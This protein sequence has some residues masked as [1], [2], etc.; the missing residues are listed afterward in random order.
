[1]RE[2]GDEAEPAQQLATLVDKLWIAQIEAEI[3]ALLARSPLAAD[4]LQQYRQLRARADEL[5]GRGGARAA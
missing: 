4:D 1:A 2:L 5:R 3:G